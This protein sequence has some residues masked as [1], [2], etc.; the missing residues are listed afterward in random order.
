LAIRVFELAKELGVTSKAMLDKCRAEDIDLKNHMAVLSAGLEATIREWFTEGAASTAVETTEHVDLK[1]EHE[2]AKKQRRRHGG[3]AEEPAEAAPPAEGAVVETAAPEAPAVPTV[4]TPAPAE[5]VVAPAS[6]APAAAPVAP[7]PE[8]PAAIEPP[9]PQAAPAV[10]EQPPVVSEP[11][12]P[13]QPSPPAEPPPV[14]APEVAAGQPPVAPPVPAIAAQAP[15][16]HGTPH[17]PPPAAPPAKSKLPFK[18]IRPA[19]TPAGPQ[20]VPR[21]A[22]LSGPRVVRVEKPDFVQAPPPRRRPTLGSISRPS[23][24]QPPVAPAAVPPPG[25]IKRPG[26]PIVVEEEDE[27]GKKAKKRSPRRR[28]GRSADSGVAAEGLKEWRDRDLAERSQRLAAATGGGLRRH[29]ASVSGG[30]PGE[31]AVRANEIELEAPISIKQ[32]S[33]ALGIKSASIIRKLMDQGTMVTVNHV[34]DEELA[35]TLAKENGIDLIIKRAQT[36]EEVLAEKLQERPKGELTSRAPVVTFLGHVDHGKTSLLDRIRKT[37]VADGEAGGITQH[38]GAYRY[39]MGNKH[40]VFLDTPGH[41][42][43]TAMRARGA[44]MTDVVVLVVAADDGVMPQTVEAISHAKAAG[45]P[46]VVALNKIDVPNANAQK[47]LGQLAEQGLQPREWGG[48]VEVLRTSAQTGEGVDTLVETLSLEAEILELKAE[49]AAPASG[50]VIEAQMSPGLGVVARLLVRDGTLKVGQV[51]L[52]GQGYGKVRRMTDSRGKD[53]DEA[54]PSTPVEVSGLDAMPEAGD[55]FYVA[56]DLDQ[57]RNVAEDRRMRARDA[58]LATVPKHTLED[59]LGRIEAGKA[60]VIS[61]IIKADVQGSIEAIVNSLNK[62][63]TPEVRVNI[64]HATV[65]GITTGDVQLA[66]ASDAIIIGFN[67]VPDANARQLAERTGVDIRHY[68]IIY[69]IID[70]IRKAL[71]EGLAPE[72]RL[73]VLGHADIRQ[74]F[75]VSR[76]GSVAGCYVTDG[77]ANRNAKVRI[78]RNNIVVEDERSLESLKRFKDDAREVRAGMECG[79]KVA[80]YDDIKEG[81]V[82]EFYQKVEVARKL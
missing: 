38:I 33:A 20:L 73:Q 70:D 21:P 41:E 13:A 78:T 43:F 54:G 53:I 39:D 22:K 24:N 74:V 27:A 55:K 46:I 48:N 25:G 17:T 36:A 18:P 31:P 65:G 69:E 82:L 52:A 81:D 32:L 40:V 79:L 6:E 45:V 44:N 77:V 7:A 12:A 71:E 2:R 67:A 51:L 37:S 16:A 15:A 72:I 61:L 75:K 80:G 10:A 11:A 28:G 56:E 66:E 23:A 19:V 57:A 8:A 62:L 68:Q 76:V 5:A 47:A 26:K 60:D 58:A 34:L 49:P 3:G 14:Q 64:L 59:I 29:R 9:A 1:K 4:E 42:A 63:S 35:K 30:G 50:Y